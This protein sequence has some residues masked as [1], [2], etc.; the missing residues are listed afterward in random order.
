MAV[1]GIIEGFTR[2][3]LTRFETV[4]RER[5]RQLLGDI[6]SLQEADAQAGSEAA[7]IPSHLADLG[8]DREASDISLGLRES[9]STEIQEIDEALDRI[10][11]GS[12][13]RCEACEKAIGKE[14]L[15]AI[16]YARLCLPC[17]KVEES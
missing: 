7:A 8:S 14:R 3:E 13:G 2:E 11:E 17:K 5:R 12:F 4:L 6:Q 15:N 1:N 16:P 9:E 10:R